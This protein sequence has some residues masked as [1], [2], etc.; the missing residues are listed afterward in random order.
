[1]HNF[2]PLMEIPY[3]YPCNFPLIHEVLLRQN[4]A[5][6][7]SLLANSRLYGLPACSGEGL[8]KA[9]FDKL[10][11]KEAV[12]I[13]KGKTERGGFDAGMAH[14]HEVIERGELLITTGT[15]YYLPYCDDYLNPLYIEKLV[16]PNSRLYLV[17]HWLAVYGMNDAGVMVYDPVPSRYKGELSMSS[18]HEF[19]RG[20]KA[21]PELAA[22][23]R[24]EEIHSY[25]TV[26]IAAERSLSP[27]SYEEAMLRVLRTQIHEFLK[28]R[29]IEIGGKSYFFG[30]A[31]SL[32]LLKQTAAFLSGENA[33]FGA[34]SALLF[35]M[36]WSRYFF[37]DFLHDLA[38]LPGHGE[39]PFALE[40]D[41]MLRCWEQA[42]KLLVGSSSALRKGKQAHRVIDFVG[43]LVRREF[44]FYERLEA[45]YSGAAVLLD[46]TD[47]GQGDALSPNR[48]NQSKLLDIVLDGCREVTL[49]HA[50]SLPGELG[51][52]T[53]LYGRDGYL[54]SLG[55][56]SLL[57]V[58]EQSIEEQLGTRIELTEMGLPQQSDNPFRTVE[59]LVNYLAG[60]LEEAG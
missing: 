40:F 52:G 45:H 35:D 56:V 43:K 4:A 32:R 28:G 12:W 29:E 33:I 3:Y 27:A 46:R 16:D 54:D 18:F 37:R 55:L 47:S 8:M 6:S 44:D 49:S 58:V 19:W 60:H 13:M 1:M 17:D 59:S 48:S 10:G 24:R 30:H 7:L 5:S 15:S 38:R 14:A 22:A 23:K 2:E 51:S 39:T 42:H 9:Y 25:C 36:R 53:A 21:I 41:D 11:Y 34:L 31:V 57:A 50:A 26:E 20:N